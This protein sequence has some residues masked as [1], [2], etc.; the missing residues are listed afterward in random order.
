MHGGCLAMVGLEVG[1]ER[2]RKRERREKA[3][4]KMGEEGSVVRRKLIGICD[5][6]KLSSP[7]IQNDTIQFICNTIIPGIFYFYYLQRH[8]VPNMF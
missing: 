5:D 4:M 7:I 3:E 8:V 2:A 6:I 1:G